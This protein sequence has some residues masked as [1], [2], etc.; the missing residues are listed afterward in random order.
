MQ[1]LL[2]AQSTKYS[3]VGHGAIYD[4]YHLVSG[5][6][7]PYPSQGQSLGL[8]FLRA[9]NMSEPTQTQTNTFR[10]WFFRCYRSPFALHC[11]G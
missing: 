1:M 10:G 5:G 11:I 2:N 3:N 6:D 9:V 7:Q 4:R 8:K